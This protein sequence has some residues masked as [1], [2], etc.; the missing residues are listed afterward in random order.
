EIAPGRPHLPGLL[1][2]G[3][4]D[5]AARR[6]CRPIDAHREEALLDEAAILGPRC[7]LLPHVAA[8]LPIDAVELVEAG[9]EQDRF[10]DDEIAAAIR[11]A[12]AK[13]EP[14]V[15]GCCAGREAG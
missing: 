8:L 12:L 7:Q 2:V 9:F 11:D 14:V 15:I 13:A 5:H 4:E 3:P 1:A 6:R 10:F